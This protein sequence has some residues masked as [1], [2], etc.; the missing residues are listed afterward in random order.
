[1]LAAREACGQAR[2][3]EAARV[4]AGTVVPPFPLSGHDLTGLGM[5]PGPALGQELA[6]LEQAWIDSGFVL[7]KLEL[8]TLARP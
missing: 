7:G 3:A 8:L 2:L 1:M 4:L 5:A 6:R